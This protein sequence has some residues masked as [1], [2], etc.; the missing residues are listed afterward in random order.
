LSIGE[1]L[2]AGRQRAGLTIAEVSQRTRI[3]ETIVR[4]IERDD[5]S[6]CGGDFYARG[7]IRAIARA[8][9]VDS[10]PLVREYD[11]EQEP[12]ED[13][14]S[15]VE[16]PQPAP[17]KPA[18][19]D[20]S[21]APGWPSMPLR[22]TERRRRPNWTI[23]LLVVL[24][25]LV[26]LVIYHVVAAD[27]SA[28]PAAGSTHAAGRRHH[29]HPAA[30][31]SASASASPSASP[32][33][34]V[35]ISLAA[36]SGACWV[37]LTTSGGGTIFQGILNPGATMSWTER[38]VVSLELGNPGVITLTVDGKTHPSLGSDPVTLS[39]GPDGQDSASPS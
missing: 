27:G 30:T 29:H 28:R 20:R 10:E 25:V 9:G 3:R 7:H 35:V 21:S 38:Q 11:A 4:E 14:P 36:G 2:A 18:K 15:A 26:G 17:V 8:A 1:A 32:S 16:T 31:G 22:I 13:A 12:A 19:P 6:G 24:A 34:D 39:L 5:F 23:A 33:G 37:N